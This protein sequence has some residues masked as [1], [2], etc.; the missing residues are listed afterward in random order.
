MLKGVHVISRSDSLSALKKPRWGTVPIGGRISKCAAVHRLP[1]VIT[2]C[3]PTYRG[4]SAGESIRA[5]G[6]GQHLNAEVGP[7]YSRQVLTVHPTQEV[8]PSL[9]DARVAKVHLKE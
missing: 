4:R 6:L 9:R 2:A 8:K 5:G 1:A 3:K 7:S